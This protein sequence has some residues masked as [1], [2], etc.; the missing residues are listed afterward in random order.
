MTTTLATTALSML[1]ASRDAEHDAPIWTDH[2]ATATRLAGT[3]RV[4]VEYLHCDLT[5]QT[6]TRRV[7]GGVEDTAT[8]LAAPKNR[9]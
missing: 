8:A 4:R 6:C 9:G 7:V 1:R 3:A 5:A 2:G